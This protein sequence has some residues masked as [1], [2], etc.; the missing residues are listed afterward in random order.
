MTQLSR[1]TLLTSAG[2]V[3]VSA[4]LGAQLPAVAGPPPRV[5][6]TGAAQAVLG[7]LL[8]K[9]AEQ[10]HLTLLDPADGG[11]RFR[12]GGARGRVEVA[13][14]S[15]AVILTGVHWYLKY[16]CDAVISWAGSQLGLPAVLP[17][18][19]SPLERRATVRHRFAFNDTYDGY[20]APYADWARWERTLDVLALH[21]CNEVFLT[22]GQEAVY[23]RV[24]QEF[25]YG[26]AEVRAWIPAPTH[27]PW[28][29]LQNMSGYGGPV[30]PELVARRAAMGRRAADRLRELGMAPVLPGYFGTVPGGFADRN[31]GAAVVPQGTWCG[32]P[33]P[34]WLDPR[35]DTFA[36]V[37]ASFYRHQRVLFDDAP[38]YKMDI[39]HEGGNAGGVDV[40]EAARGIERA[41]QAARPGATWVILGWTGNPRPELLAALDKTHVLIVDGRSELDESTDREKEW[42]NTPYAFGAIPNFGGRTT[43]GAMAPSWTQKFPAWRDKAGSALTGTA[44]LPESTDRDPAAF[45]LFTE[46]A[47]REEPVDRAAWFTRYARFR[48]GGPDQQATAAFAALRDTAYD[49]QSSDGRPHDS[50]FAAR[51]D[52]AAVNATYYG[53]TQLSF[54]SAG[55]DLAF[56]GLLAVSAPLRRSEAYR[57][58]L[59][60]FARQA[61]AN[62]SRQLLPQLRAAYLRKDREAFAAL[63]GLWLKLMRLSDE[64]TGGHRAFMLGPWLDEARRYASSPAETA[65]LEHSA[66]ALITTW[67]DRAA[68][69]TG[70]LDNYANRDWQGLIG[71]FHLPQW[72]SYLDEMADALAQDRAPRVFDWYAVEEPWTRERKSYP[73]RE[74]SA[75]G[76]HRVARRVYETLA[77]APYQ[78]TVTVA[79]DRAAVAPGGAA[80]VE[81]DFRNVNGLRATGPV[82]FSLGAPG[83]DAVAQG[84]VELPGV[85]AGGSARA[86]WRVTAPAAAPKEPL[87]PHP[88]ELRTE[89][90]P[91]GERPVTAVTQGRI[92]VAGPLDAQW[93]THNANDASFGQAA[94]R[95]AIDGA[96]RDLWGSTAQFGAVYRTAAYGDGAC[97][98]V[99]VDSQEYTGNWARAGIVVR[100]AMAT[101]GSRG[102]LN[103]ALTPVNG[104]VLSYDGNGDGAL[105]KRAS[106]LG[107]T[108]P[109]LLR[110]T[111]AGAAYT[112]SCST[113]GGATWQTLAAVTVPGAVAVQ[114][115]GF[116]MTAANGGSGRRGR[117]EFSG[118]SLTG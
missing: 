97:V 76:V 21:G 47:W 65:Q 61:L 94:D 28:W 12:V 34:D 86:S 66:R 49:V 59:T 98:T 8:G 115:V 84:P 41:L 69:D 33:R 42:G 70:L 7:R 85:E 111:R 103:L 11:E 57:F 54:D 55:F 2:A 87:E 82:R 112:G 51:P 100:N 96:G 58:D 48:Y 30:T 50:L 113:D 45:E 17:A 102:F 106:V 9:H 63:S 117:A 92:Y 105:E 71:D 19:G 43:L 78:G 24:M 36:Q 10:F 15:P 77:A 46:L 73:L 108:G 79:A 72:Q 75:S 90:G 35:T 93:L 22:V 16:V 1:R 95:F 25:G 52:L 3:G 6:G 88:F 104:V 80:V 32:F 27:Q 107:V 109:V 18:P 53:T 116:F 60:D 83:L 20:T 110:L 99:R 62:R 26:D 64:V 67:G 91:L 81:A 68:A 118:W 31:P 5:T 4:A 114:D 40:P 44:Y 13:G 39:L 74:L 89:Y 29:L 101:T 38:S 56:A 14:T 37:A 23:H